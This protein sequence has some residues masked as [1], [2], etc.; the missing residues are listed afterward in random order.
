[1][2]QAIMVR[3]LA[4]KLLA[5]VTAY[6]IPVTVIDDTPMKSPA[7]MYSSASLAVRTISK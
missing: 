6:Y 7:H 4:D 2:E 3:H 5:M 1:M